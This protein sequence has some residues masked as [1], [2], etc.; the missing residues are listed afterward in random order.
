MRRLLTLIF[1]FLLSLG[2][3]QVKEIDTIQTNS[4]TVLYSNVLKSPIKLS[5][6]IDPSCKS[7]LSRKGYRF[8]PYPGVVNKAVNENYGTRYDNGHL[9]PA[10]SFSCTKDKLR[11]TFYLINITMQDKDLNRGLWKSLENYE[12]L[13][14]Y[15]Y[16]QKVYVTVIVD[17]RSMTKFGNTYLPDGYYKFVTEGDIVTRYYFPN[18]S[19]KGSLKD[20]MINQQSITNK[21]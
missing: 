17:Y 10:E 9:A 7:V 15:K 13:A 1:I 21:L 5:Y 16:N 19:V 18:K 20:F 2:Y 12:R 4:Y 14:S 8:K 11:D 6:V 3:C